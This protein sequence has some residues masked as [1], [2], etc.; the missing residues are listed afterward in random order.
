MPPSQHVGFHGHGDETAV[1]FAYACEKVEK[2]EIHS[3][4]SEYNTDSECILFDLF[5]LPLHPMM[6]SLY[7]DQIL[8]A[9]TRKG[10]EG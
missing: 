9:W 2:Q 7:F 10:I 5:S 3:C 4:W 6:S 8:G 1:H